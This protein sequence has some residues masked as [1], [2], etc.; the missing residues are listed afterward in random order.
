MKILFVSAVLPYPL[1]SGGQ[2]RIYN[3]LKRLGGSHEIH[4]YSFIRAESEKKYLPQLSFCT[5]VATVLRGRV[6]QPKYLLKTLTGSYPLLWSSYYNSDMLTALADE[7]T[8]GNYDLIHIEPGYVWPSI[9]TEHRIPIVVAEH[10]IEHEVYRKYVDAFPVSFL[11]P[12]LSLDVSKM[13]AWEKRCW[14][15]ASAIV[16]VSE[17]DKRF[18]G[19]PNVSV[20]SNGVDIEAYPFKP[21]KTPGFRFLY[22]GNFRWMENRDAADYLRGTIWPVIKKQY[23]QATLRIVGKGAPDGAVERIQDELCDADIMIAPI[24]IGGG[25]K[26]K[27]L[28]AMACG[29]PVVTT[30]IGAEG[31]DTKALWIADTPEETMMRIHE[32]GKN[33]Q[34][35][36]YGRSLVEREYNWDSIAKKLDHVW[37]SLS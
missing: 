36:T 6:W 33:K 21:K 17:S 16:A 9:P 12:F 11:K 26:F 37:N 8:V 4:L 28:E 22:T 24:R 5:S 32:I 3:L 30:T 14:S 19:K 2:I 27:I 29:L 34:K 23:P 13:I 7:I 20:V 15:K 1:H 31:I 10:N 18:I 25:T 35:I